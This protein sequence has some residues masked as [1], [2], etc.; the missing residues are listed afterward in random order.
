MS[1]N[2]DWELAEKVSIYKQLQRDGTTA[3]IE[4]LGAKTSDTVVTV[5]LQN[6]FRAGVLDYLERHY[7]KISKECTGEVL[8]ALGAR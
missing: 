4:G 6:A 5:V 7:P 1:N 3:A 8:N 2:C